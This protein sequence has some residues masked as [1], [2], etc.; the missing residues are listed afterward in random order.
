MKSIDN[1]NALVSY[2]RHPNDKIY[3]SNGTDIKGQSYFRMP[4]LTLHSTI[5]DIYGIEPKDIKR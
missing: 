1:P 3:G 5:A 4:P 2:D